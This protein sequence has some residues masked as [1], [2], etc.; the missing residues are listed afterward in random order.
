MVATRVL[1]HAEDNTLFQV[2]PAPGPEEVNWPVLCRNWKQREMR[3]A[4]VIP[5][6]IILVLLPISLA[7][8][9]LASLDY[10]FCAGQE[11]DSFSLRCALNS[12]GWIC[13]DPPCILCYIRRWVGA[14]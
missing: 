11:A 8:G 5:F 1:L 12:G 6:I 2:R 7:T 13:L 9:A 3:A 10:A 4:V 14:T